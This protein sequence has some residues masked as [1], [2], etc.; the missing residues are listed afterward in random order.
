MESST[1]QGTL[2]KMAL[3]IKVVDIEGNQISFWRATGRYFSKIVSALL[4]CIG[5]LM[6]AFTEKKQALHDK[7]ADCLVVN[8]NISP[9]QLIQDGIAT[10]LSNGAI[11][12]LILLSLIVIL[13]AII[14]IR[15]AQDNPDFKKAIAE[16]A[17]AEKTIADAE[18]AIAQFHESYSQG[19]LDDIW[20]EA[21]AKFRSVST[22][23]KYDQFMG[24]VQR[25]LGKV[26]STSN[27]GWKVKWSINSKTTVFMTQETIFE[28]GQGTES[29]TFEIDGTN[30]VLVDYNMQS[31]DLI[32][33]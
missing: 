1:K 15:Y 23:Q 20:K 12:G 24:A 7:M 16:K 2:G 4:F 6:I 11:F 8:K 18:K 33:K 3:S 10:K 25:K 30:A 26:T 5:Y 28:H 19:K 21:D 17:I 9:V 29:F 27:A 13:A 31:M 22:K 14:G 32:T